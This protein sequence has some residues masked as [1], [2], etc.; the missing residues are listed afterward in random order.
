M[1]IPTVYVLYVCFQVYTKKLLPI[2]GK[3]R[4]LY[5][6]FLRLIVIFFILWLVYVLYA[7]YEQFS[8]PEL[9]GLIFLGIY[10]LTGF[11]SFC[12][13]I[14]KPDVY[15]AVME[16]SCKCL[17]AED[18]NADNNEETNIQEES[19]SQ[20]NDKIYNNTENVEM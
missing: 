6:Y 17:K 18:N 2:T 13:A 15:E 16:F 12:F 19:S 4:L 5:F 20:G 8:W 9:L 7:F 3:T 10:N 14:T 11:I 1:L